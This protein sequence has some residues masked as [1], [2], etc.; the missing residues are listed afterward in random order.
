[1]D[2]H[3]IS[4]FYLGNFCDPVTPERHKPSLWVVDVQK[5]T[6]KRRAPKN[7]AT[8][9]DYYSFVRADGKQDRVVDEILEHTET[10]VAPVISKIRCGDFK[11]TKNERAYLACFMALFTTRVPLF[12]KFVEEKAGEAGAAMLWTAAAHPEYF[13]RLIKKTMGEVSEEE[14]ERMRQGALDP[15]DYI[16]RGT[17]E[18]S[19]DQVVR[20]ADVVAPIIF[21]MQWLFLGTPQ[22][23]HFL[24]TDVPV[25]WADPSQATPDAGTGLAMPNTIL[26][27]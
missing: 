18:F 27:W 5:E 8:Q 20:Q 23:S 9:A 15:K 22:G 14:V 2:Q 1:M 25:V 7:V 12:R 26:S 24:T 10:A 21:N 13:K 4:R 6:V 3:I 11:L 16:I 17:P 19:L